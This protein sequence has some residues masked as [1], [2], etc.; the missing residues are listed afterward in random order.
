MKKE[1]K[2]PKIC[3]LNCPFEPPKPKAKYN[4]D[5][6]SAEAYKELY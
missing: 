2:D 4:V 5:I 1:I 6:K 3:I